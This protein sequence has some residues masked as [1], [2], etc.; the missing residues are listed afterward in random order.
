MQVA[1]DVVDVRITQLEDRRAPRWL[2]VVGPGGRITF[3]VAHENAPLTSSANTTFAASSRTSS[4]TSWR[5]RLDAPT[6]LSCG[7]RSDPETV[8]LALGWDVRPSSPRLRDALT[9]GM[10]E[11]GAHVLDIGLVPTPVPVLRVPPPRHG[12]R[13]HDHG[14]SQSPEYNGFK[15]GYRDLPFTGAEIQR[16]REMIEADDCRR[17]GLARRPAGDRGLL[18]HSSLRIDLAR[19]VNVVLDPASTAARFS[20]GICSSESA[21]V[22]IACTTK[23]T[24][25]SPNHHPDTVDEYVV[26]LRRRVVGTSRARYRPGWR[27]RSNRRGGRD[28]SPRPRRSADRHLRPRPARPHAGADDSVRR[29]VL[30]VSR[31]HPRPRWKAVHVEDRPQPRSSR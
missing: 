4:R 22:S 7:G 29:E 26:D 6:R 28:R 1:C 9:G 24:D 18:R 31:G 8:T 15:L 5:V 11:A 17:S 20:Q 2:Q 25:A 13:R 27:L 23:S 30:A 19:P 3:A 21:L 14:K 10:L 12:R 16:V